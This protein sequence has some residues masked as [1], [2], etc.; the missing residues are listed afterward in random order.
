MKAR[1]RFDLTLMTLGFVMLFFGCGRSS[2][3]ENTAP[4]TDVVLQ[5]PGMH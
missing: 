4:T 3:T 5:V 2:T 1:F